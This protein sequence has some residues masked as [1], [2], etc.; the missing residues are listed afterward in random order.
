MEDVFSLGAAHR[1]PP[2]GDDEISAY[3]PDDNQLQ[4][5]LVKKLILYNKILQSTYLDQWA[6][7]K[8]R[9]ARVQ[10]RDYSSV[11]YNNKC[12]GMIG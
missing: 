4:C 1:E 12:R 3:L 8:V 9:Q 2:G 11:N 7:H 6:Q 10:Q 5:G